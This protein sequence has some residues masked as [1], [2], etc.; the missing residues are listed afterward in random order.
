MIGKENNLK[1][2]K[3]LSERGGSYACRIM[4]GYFLVTS[5]GSRGR[6]VCITRNRILQRNRRSCHRNVPNPI[7]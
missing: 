1:T 2:F 4:I 5:P 6:G 7:T 3:C